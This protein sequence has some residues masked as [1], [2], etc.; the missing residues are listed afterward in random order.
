MTNI[1]HMESISNE[2]WCFATFKNYIHPTDKV[3]IIPFSFHQDE[4]HSQKDF[5]AL[6]HPDFGKYY[7]S[8]MNGFHH[9]G[10]PASQIYWMNYFSA[11]DK[12]DAKQLVRNA[13]IIYFTGGLPDQLKERL[14]EFD[15]VNSLEQFN[16]LIMDF[17]AG[18]MIQLHRVHMTPD[19]DY[20][21]YFYMNGLNILHGFDIECHF[22]NTSL[23]Q[24]A[25][26]QAINDYHLPV[27]AIGD[28]GAIIV[29][30]GQLTCIGDVH[31]FL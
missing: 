16:G 27:Y 3:L 30:N 12:A 26:Q 29:E 24:T 2:E 10:I 1:L 4:V 8:I 20:D 17:S 9:Y 6:Y 22:E 21:H 19:E 31:L 5:D 13:D 25:I 18:A 28:K 7:A 14:I 23:Q 11:K 15:L